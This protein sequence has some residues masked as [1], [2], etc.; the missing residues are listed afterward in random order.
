MDERRGREMQK[1]RWGNM[2]KREAIEKNGRRG[3]DGRKKEGKGRK[4]YSNNQ[5]QESEW[6]G[7]GRGKEEG[8]EVR[9][10]KGEEDKK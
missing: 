5:N 4:K 1:R 7:K 6:R 3:L 2:R 8:K 10:E 9:E